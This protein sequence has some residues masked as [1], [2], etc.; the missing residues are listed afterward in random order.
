M[1]EFNWYDTHAVQK[2]GDRWYLL[3]KVAGCWEY[4][5]TDETTPLS[6]GDTYECYRTE[7]LA[8]AWLLSKKG[9]PSNG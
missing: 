9:G 5:C 1:D 4:Y 7:L 3:H 6:L 8:K 2:V